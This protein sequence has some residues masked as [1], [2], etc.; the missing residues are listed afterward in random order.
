MRKLAS[1]AAAAVMLTAL[2]GT[3]ASSDAAGATATARSQHVMRFVIRSIESSRPSLY[4]PVGVDRLR[5]PATHRIV[6]YDSFAGV[7]DPSNDRLRFWLS[8]SVT[9]GMVDTYFDLDTDTITDPDTGV[10]RFAGRITRGYGAFR[11]ITGKLHVR[12]DPTGRT[13]Y[14]L[15]YR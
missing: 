2:A 14:T 15:R 4:H 6:G 9:S 5:S 7:F 13:V 12:T 3:S 8:I 1:T 11:G 10:T